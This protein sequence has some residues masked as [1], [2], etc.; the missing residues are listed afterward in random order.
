[1]QTQILKVAITAAL[2][3]CAVAIA[4]FARG[5]YEY[6]LRTQSQMDQQHRR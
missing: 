5:A 3:V 6:S 2:L 1:M 4:A